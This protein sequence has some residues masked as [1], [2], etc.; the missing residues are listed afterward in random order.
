MSYIKKFPIDS[1][2]LTADEKKIVKKLVAAAE[3]I[4]PLYAKQKNPQYP[5]ANFYP[6]DATRE[7]IENAAKKN[8][9][10]LNPYTFVERDKSGKLVAVP[11]SKKFKKE[12]TAVAKLLREAATL[13][14]DKALKA[15]LVARAD[16]LLRDN[17]DKSNVLWLKT[18]KSKIGFVIGAFDRFHDK[19]FFQ[20]RG[21]S[22][23]VGILDSQKTKE[24][25]GFRAAI[26]ASEKRHLP[27]A[28]SAKVSQIK[29]RVEHTHMLSGLDA[30][31]LFVS[32][33]LP[34]SADLHIIKKDGTI[35]TL[36]T[37][38]MDWRYTNWILPVYQ[39]LFA[40]SHEKVCSEQELWKAFVRICVL[41]EISHS[42]MRYEDAA[43][44]LQE[45]FAYL[46]EI[47]GDILTIKNSEYLFLKGALTER[48]LQA[49]MLAEISHGLYYFVSAQKRPHL[50]PLAVGYACFFDFLLKGGALKKTKE[51]FEVDFQRAFIAIDE[52]A[53]VFEYYL[54]LAS[55]DDTK[56]FLEKFD[57]QDVLKQFAPSLQK[58]LRDE[59]L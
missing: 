3:L 31:F 44:R 14:K 5:G 46:N 56:E 1:S 6:H 20:K 32:N 38:L 59:K 17:L 57:L 39:N 28:K 53:H 34:S 21:Y 9:A 50:A 48:E 52:L 40:N 23:W 29:I 35:C 10:I 45:T 18:D 11:Y 30:D 36:F 2:E 51:G 15:Y 47:Y 55:R 13:S 25:E 49:I 54:S 27:G 12:L 33:N 41:D 24:M 19:L 37:P 42:L 8:A 26:L 4:D 22:A 43:K 7:E 16:D 58:V